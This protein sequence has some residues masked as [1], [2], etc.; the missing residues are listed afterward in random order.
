MVKLTKAENAH[1][2]WIMP[3]LHRLNTTFIISTLQ[4][5]PNCIKCQ[6]ILQ[7]LNSK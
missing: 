2:D 5:C 1:L 6:K 4:A 7:Q 3:G